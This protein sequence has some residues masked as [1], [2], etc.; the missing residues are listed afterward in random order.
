M[1][2]YRKY[3]SSIQYTFFLSIIIVGCNKTEDKTNLLLENFKYEI[4]PTEEEYNKPNL[5]EKIGDANS[6]IHFMI[7][8]FIHYP[9][10]HQLYVKLWKYKGKATD[11]EIEDLIQNMKYEINNNT[12]LISKDGLLY[13]RYK[14]ETEVDLKK[15]ISNF[16]IRLYDN[17]NHKLLREDILLGN[18][19]L[20]S[21]HVFN[22]KY[23]FTGYTMNIETAYRLSKSWIIDFKVSD[24]LYT[25]GYYKY[26]E[27]Y[28]DHLSIEIYFLGIHPTLS[29]M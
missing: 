26:I 9:F 5:S 23:T 4:F 1:N 17:K 6:K 19:G 10:V 12:Y 22:K 7:E 15:Y 28:N 24:K 27:M 25:N 16:V 3:F 20:D 21:L 18:V 14:M 29:K 8:E 13:D 11:K 2:T